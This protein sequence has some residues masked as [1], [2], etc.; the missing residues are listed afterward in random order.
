MPRRDN[1][2]VIMT[3]VILTVMR[4]KDMRRVHPEQIEGKCARCGEV[5]GIYPSGQKVMRD[6]PGQVELVCQI[7]NDPPAGSALA[8]GAEL[9]PFESR[10]SKVN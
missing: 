6:Y 3:S 2:G 9:E 7:C 10:P 8:P 4:L 5:V 1:R